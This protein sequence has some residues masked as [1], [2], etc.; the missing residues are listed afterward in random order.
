MYSSSCRD[1]II[2]TIF[3]SFLGTKTNPYPNQTLTLTLTVILIPTLILFQF[4]VEQFEVVFWRHYMNCCI[5]SESRLYKGFRIRR[6]G[7]V[8]VP[9]EL[10]GNPCT[11]K[12][13]NSCYV[14]SSLS[15]I[16]TWSITRVWL[17]QLHKVR[18]TCCL[19]GHLHSPLRCLRHLFVSWVQLLKSRKISFFIPT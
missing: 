17:L 5:Y 9:L 18:K 11:M 19:V 10:I 13:S 6:A 3:G 14:K 4:K 7:I 1:V 12:H 16:N 2:S 15:V 8:P